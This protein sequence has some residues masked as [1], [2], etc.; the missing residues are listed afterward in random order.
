MGRRACGPSC[1]GQFSFESEGGGG[2]GA[3]SDRMA[4][5]SRDLR[6]LLPALPAA[7][8]AEIWQLARL[9]VF[10]DRVKRAW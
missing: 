5:L 2:G 6:E 3:L 10:G 4:S 7:R 8:G 1:A 9:E